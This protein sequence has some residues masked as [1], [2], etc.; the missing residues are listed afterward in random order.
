MADDKR[1]PAGADEAAFDRAGQ[2]AVEGRNTPPVRPGGEGPAAG[3]HAAQPLTTPEATPGSGA[4][5]GKGQAD[6]VDP[7]ID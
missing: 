5:P 4:L 7:A 3:P 6:E 2:E 1:T